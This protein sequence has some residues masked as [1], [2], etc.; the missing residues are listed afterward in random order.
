MSQAQAESNRTRRR[1]LEGA[2]RRQGPP[3]EGDGRGL[4]H[5]RPQGRRR[6]PLARRQRPC[7]LD[8]RNGRHLLLNGGESQSVP[9]LSPL[10]FQLNPVAPTRSGGAADADR[11]RRRGRGLD[12]VLRLALPEERRL[13]RPDGRDRHRGAHPGRQGRPDADHPRPDAARHRRDRGLPPHPPELGRADPDADRA[14]R[15]RRQDHRA[16]GR[17][18]RLPDEAVQPARARRARQVDPAPRDARAAR[19]RRARSSSTAT[20][21]STPAGAR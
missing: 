21:R 2:V 17:R 14:R 10:F 13:R 9:L 18:R 3:L 4:Q 19:D 5:D 6:R 16:R 12:R 1:R 11:A 8:A 20:C 7:R 15:G